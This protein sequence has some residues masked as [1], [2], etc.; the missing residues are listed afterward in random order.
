MAGGRRGGGGGSGRAERAENAAST[1]QQD[2]QHTTMTL[3]SQIKAPLQL[4]AA[5]SMLQGGGRGKELG[6]KTKSGKRII[7]CQKSGSPP[8]SFSWHT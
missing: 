2:Q 8:S 5:L 6:G 7:V 3:V 1:Q 4:P